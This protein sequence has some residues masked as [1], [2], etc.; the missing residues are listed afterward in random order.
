MLV[1]MLWFHGRTTDLVRTQPVVLAQDWAQESITG[2]RA[3]EKQS[4]VDLLAP[5]PLWKMV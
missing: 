4:R 5:L 2:Q 1:N 3:V